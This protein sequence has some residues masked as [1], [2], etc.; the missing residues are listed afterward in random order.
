MN[1]N[2]NSPAYNL[3]P[4]PQQ[5]QQPHQP[6]PTPS[7]QPQQ[8]Q[9]QQYYQD[10]RQQPQH[11]VSPVRTQ[12]TE[13][14]RY[15]PYATPQ[16]RST[17]E[18][19][20]NG[21]RRLEPTINRYPSDQDTYEGS[22]VGFKSSHN[23]LSMSPGPHHRNDGGGSSSS[24]ISATLPRPTTRRNIIQEDEDENPF[25]DD[26]QHPPSYDEIPLI[27]DLPPSPNRGV[28]SQ[29]DSDHSS[30]PTI[31][32]GSQ[33]VPV[34]HNQ[35]RDSF[36]I[37]TPQSP[38]SPVQKRGMSN[39]KDEFVKSLGGRGGGEQQ[40]GAGSGSSSSAVRRPS[41]SGSGLPVVAGNRSEETIFYQEALDELRNA[42]DI[43]E[44]RDNLH[45]LLRTLIAK[46]NYLESEKQVQND[47][48]KDL[49][50]RLDG[51]R[52]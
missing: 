39:A 6:Y 20:D 5:H 21:Y 19:G 11:Q 9:Q 4:T 49:E 42:E 45:G 22:A 52:K 13:N 38:G 17:R 40:G 41:A 43:S 31:F 10:Q 12:V 25:L 8:Q 24:T 2:Q 27:M 37:I 50:D 1:M 32:P 36:P 33:Q 14:N 3:P 16:Q 26:H 29:S 46:V 7:Q 18:D 47:R 15:Q 34:L 48:I 51:R 44:L 35:R 28:L 23:I 30:Q